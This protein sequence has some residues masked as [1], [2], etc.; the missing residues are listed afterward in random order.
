MLKLDDG[1]HLGKLLQMAKQMAK[2]TKILCKGRKAVT[3]VS[4]D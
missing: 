2:Q 1:F 4:W 3:I